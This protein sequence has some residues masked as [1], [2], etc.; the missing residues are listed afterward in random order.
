[1]SLKRASPSVLS[2][3][4]LAL[5]AVWGFSR[6]SA[7]LQGASASA[8]PT[9]VRAPANGTM[10]PTVFMPLAINNCCF[11][12]YD[13][14]SDPTTG[15]STDVESYGT[16]AYVNGIYRITRV[17]NT[18]YTGMGSSPDWVVPDQATISV[19][20]WMPEGLDTDTHSPDLGLI[21]GLEHSHAAG[22]VTWH[23]WYSFNIH[24]A[25]QWW[26]VRKWEGAGETYESV[27]V[28]TSTAIIAN[29]TAHQLL[30]VRR[31]A[32][33]FTLFINGV[34]IKTITDTVDPILGR[35]SVGVSAGSFLTAEFDNFEVRANGCITMLDTPAAQ[36][37]A[38]MPRLER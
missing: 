25:H 28:D 31:D 11:Y 35:G 8:E 4:L 37:V 18:T 32:N 15:W 12:V 2:C 5:S 24:P 30:A 27:D 9:V 36:S 20:A 38:T 1:M 21:F 7:T 6:P 3:L 33:T 23:R 10:S 19:E 22:E 13:D 29:L 34:E 14:F 16:Y 26:S 17:S